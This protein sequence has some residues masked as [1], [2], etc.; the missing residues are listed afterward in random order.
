LRIED[1]QWRCTW[2]GAFLE[3]VPLEQ[4]PVV[5]LHASGGEPNVRVVTVDGVE[6]HRCVEPSHKYA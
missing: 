1:G 2:C 4:R 6:V 5:T 3:G